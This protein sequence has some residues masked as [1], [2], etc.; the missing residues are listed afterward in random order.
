MN[1]LNLK[2]VFA[3]GILYGAGRYL[4]E[5]RTL[6]AFPDCE[7]PTKCFDYAEELAASI[8]PREDPCDNLYDHVCGKW[9][10]LHPAFTPGSWNQ[11]KLLQVR[12]REFLLGQLE[13]SPHGHPVVAVRRSVTA[14]QI[15]REV[16]TEWRNDTKVLL[17][18]FDKFNFQ[19]P[20]VT[21]PS[22]FDLMEYLLGMSLE[23]NLATPV[24]L[25]FTP[26]VKP[27][28]RYGLLFQIPSQIENDTVDT[29]V[30]ADCILDVAPATTN[31][32]AWT[33]AERIHSVFLDFLTAKSALSLPEREALVHTTIEKLANDTTGHS[34]GEAWLNAINKRLPHDQAVGKSQHVLTVKN[35]G[36]L[37]K[38]ILDSTKRSNYADLVLY[39]GWNIVVDLRAALSRSLSYCM[40]KSP[41]RY[42]RSSELLCLDYIN[43]VAP[44]AIG[45][46]F[47]D[48]LEL[49]PNV[50]YTKNAWNA[51]KKATRE[52]FANLSW[53]DKSTAKG[54]VEHVDSLLTILP[55]PDHLQT[56]EALDAHYGFLYPNV[57]QP[58][59]QWLLKTKQRRH[60]EQKRLFKQA[61]VSVYHDDFR[62]S[63]YEV[64]AFYMPIMHVMALMPAIMAPPF[65]PQAV[66]SAVHY[67]AIGK[68]L[69]HELTHAFDPLFSNLTRNGV[70]AMPWSNES[71]AN[72]SS[73]LQC[74]SKQLQSFT[75]DEV[76]SK[77]VLS[78]TFADT[79]G[80]EK[81]WLAY[82]SLPAQ[83]GILGYTQEQSFYIAG[84]FEFCAV[85]GYEWSTK[86]LY[87]ADALRCN[88][89]ARNEKEFAAAFSCPKGSAMN[90]EERCTFH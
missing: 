18:V 56:N 81:A 53:M 3:L 70:A 60:D 87:P 2:V 83:K 61:A 78:E 31:D 84:C 46:F 41:F 12:A 59:I 29:D 1:V 67:G 9:D 85:G 55:F 35:S 76:H 26:D 80:T 44:F 43:Q 63:A 75:D 19:W 6:L 8:D 11:A 23:Y 33:F 90:P 65:A 24:L 38:M 73:R 22:E 4:I 89:P 51:V 15:C 71:F 50:N 5:E 36:L 66:Q 62:Y 10:R 28:K 25:S 21:L 34:T 17:D 14:F 39:A 74:V 52:N 86:S 20:S 27:D 42:Q 40:S 72:F 13:Q 64:N 30:I 68:I 16:Y 88:I 82:S 57:S 79:G 47:V 32:S 54:A 77:N 58:F 7:H 48:S 45:R 49:Q 69:G 37:L